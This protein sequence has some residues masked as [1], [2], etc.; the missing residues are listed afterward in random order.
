MQCPDDA[1]VAALLVTNA[2]PVARG[3]FEDHID[4]CDS[5][6]QLLAGLIRRAELDEARAWRPGD[7]AGRY[8][9]RE[10][11]G[12]GGMGAVYRAD[13]VELGRPV[14]LKRLHADDAERLVREARS[15]A[16]LQHPNVVTVYE[17][18]DNGGAPF[19][20]MEF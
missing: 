14:A 11:I 16:Q 13:D 4:D 1:A 17:V 6:R 12:R 18:V 10:R 3:L 9:I 19:L 8:I 20:A 7:R 5:C 15:A 2:P